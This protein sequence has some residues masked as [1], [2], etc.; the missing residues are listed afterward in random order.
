M[1]EKN[2]FVGKEKS[3]DFSD[4]KK[5]SIE[6]LAELIREHLRDRNMTIEEFAE[7]SGVSLRHIYNILGHKT[8]PSLE[9]TEK[10]IK[11]LGL[12]IW[13]TRKL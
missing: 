9:I 12:E 13:I 4:M 11:V 5:L 1:R 7:K 3:A 8:S 2:K 10:I 6:V